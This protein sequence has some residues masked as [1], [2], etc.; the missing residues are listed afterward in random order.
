MLNHSGQKCSLQYINS[1]FV[2]LV[3][4]K[5]V[6]NAY[7]LQT[8]FKKEILCKA[9]QK[10][11]RYWRWNNQ[12]KQQEQCRFHRPGTLLTNLCPAGAGW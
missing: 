1:I 6:L 4:Y 2:A 8:P 3:K 12:Y 5:V 11:L 10:H 9:N 7:F